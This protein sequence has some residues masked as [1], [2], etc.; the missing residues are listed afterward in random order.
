MIK[1]L[2]ETTAYS[3]TNIVL[4]KREPFTFCQIY[5]ELVDLGIE[6]SKCAVRLTLRRLRDRGI[7]VEQGSY[8]SLAI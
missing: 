7:I 3:V 6:E 5:N 1:P 4:T 8:Y 2:I